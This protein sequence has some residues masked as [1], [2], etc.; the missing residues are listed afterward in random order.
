M[1]EVQWSCDKDNGKEDNTFY[2]KIISN[3]VS[4][5]GNG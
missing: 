3:D 5:G 2:Y 4:V 1:H